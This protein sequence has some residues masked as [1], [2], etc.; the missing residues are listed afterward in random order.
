MGFDIND[1]RA[2]DLGNGRMIAFGLTFVLLVYGGIAISFAWLLA[3]LLAPAASKILVV[4][5]ILLVFALIPTW[6]IVPSRLYFSH[7]CETQSGI[8]RSVGHVDDLYGPELGAGSAV[9]FL[10]ML[11]LP[12]IQGKG[13][14]GLVQFTLNKHGGLNRTDISEP[15]ASYSFVRSQEPMPLNM[16]KYQETIAV[17][18]TGEIVAVKTNYCHR[19]NW[20]QVRSA[21]LLGGGEYCEGDCLV[22]ADFLAAVLSPR[23]FEI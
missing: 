10:K 12:Y 18:E 22:S 17:R 11:G 4:I 3:R 20:L 7:L 2:V 8:Y 23:K 16:V 19:G 21:P 13:L 15:S 1:W 6:D 14:R 5:L 9:H